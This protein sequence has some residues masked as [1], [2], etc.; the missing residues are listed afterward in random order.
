MRCL[1]HKMGKG[2]FWMLMRCLLQSICLLLMQS[3]C[4]PGIP[5]DLIM[6]GLDEIVC[7]RFKDAIGLTIQEA[8]FSRCIIECNLLSITYNS[9][10]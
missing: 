7:F 10:C 6:H 5:G 2:I 1:L 8:D 4:R 3:N 9:I